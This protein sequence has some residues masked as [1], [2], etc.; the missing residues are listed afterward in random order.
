MYTV[1]PLAIKRER[2]RDLQKKK[3]G[4]T[5]VRDFARSVGFRPG[6]GTLYYVREKE[7]KKFLCARTL[8]PPVFYK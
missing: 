7:K 6:D 4:W 8:R 5:M 2:E 1:N 3:D